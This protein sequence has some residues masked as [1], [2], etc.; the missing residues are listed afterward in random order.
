ME[1]FVGDFIAIPYLLGTV[2]SE[3]KVTCFVCLERTTHLAVYTHVL[4]YL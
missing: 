4:S 1:V 3:V 2:E